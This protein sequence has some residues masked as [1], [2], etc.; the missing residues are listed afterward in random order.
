MTQ[1]SGDLRV[2]RTRKLLREALIELIKEQGFDKLTVGEIAQRAMVSRA[3]FYRHYLDKYDLVEKI[4]E[5]AQ[6]MILADSDPTHSPLSNDPD[7]PP[8]PWIKIFEHFAEY[9]DLYR[10]LLGS[11]GSSWFSAKLHELLAKLIIERSQ[12][13][14]TIVQ[15]QITFPSALIAGII[16]TAVKWWLEHPE[17]YTPREIATYCY[18]TTFSLAQKMAV[19]SQSVTV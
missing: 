4:F 18:P 11:R 15:D 13:V 9:K 6:H 12:A 3:A 19:R 5:D 10:E 14:K 17:Q 16:I 8:E 1:P 2:R 7:H